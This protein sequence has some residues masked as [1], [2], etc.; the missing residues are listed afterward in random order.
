MDE[1]ERHEHQA[2]AHNDD[3]SDE[4]RRTFLKGALLTGGL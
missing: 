2:H 1:N 4:G 3:G